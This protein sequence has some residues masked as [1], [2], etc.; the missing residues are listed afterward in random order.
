MVLKGASLA[1]LVYPDAGLRMY[2]D[3]DILVKEE[4]LPE[5]EKLIPQLGYIPTGNSVKQQRHK[6][7]HYHLVPYIHIDKNIVLEIHWNVTNRFHLNING[8]WQRSRIERIMGCPARVLSQNDLFQH[9]CIHTSN[10]GFRNIDLRDLCDIFETIKC[11]GEEIDWARFRKE[12]DT[13]PIH[14]EVYSILYYVKRMFSSNVSCLNWLTNQ[15]ADLKLI[16]L[17]EELIF[18]NDRDK[19]TLRIISS[20]SIKTGFKDKFKAVMNKF[21]PDREFMSIRYFLPLFSKKIYFYYMVHPLIL[22]IGYRK[23]I[24]RFF[25]L[26]AKE[27]F[28]NASYALRRNA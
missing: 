23:Y 17:L 9:L 8:W 24:G 28:I 6:E 2:G 7:K 25:I 14:R 4:D 1:N 10:H 11:H 5:V 3:I 15:Q 13:Y 27:F 12:I 26:M 22:I 21:F 19:I 18:C 16:S 20:I